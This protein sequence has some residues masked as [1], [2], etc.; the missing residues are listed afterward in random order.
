MGFDGGEVLVTVR[1]HWE[2]LH[3]RNKA[4]FVQDSFPHKMRRL[5]SDH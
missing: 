4:Q 2:S 3:K 5:A 1:S